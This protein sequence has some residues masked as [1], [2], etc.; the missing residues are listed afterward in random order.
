MGKKKKILLI[1]FAAVLVSGGICWRILS[2]CSAYGTLK[3]SEDILQG[4][5]FRKISEEIGNGSYEYDYKIESGTWAWMV[6]CDLYDIPTEAYD[7][8]VRGSVF[9]AVPRNPEDAVDEKIIFPLDAAWMRC[10]LLPGREQCVD[11]E[12]NC[13]AFYLTVS[14][15][16]SYGSML[17]GVDGDSIKECKEIM[18]M[19]LTKLMAD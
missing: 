13:P 14:G 17:V 6:G 18:E 5:S 7:A 8:R 4:F 9:I 19:F 2:E 12:G 3:L 10:E 11:S 16:T 1:V 15:S